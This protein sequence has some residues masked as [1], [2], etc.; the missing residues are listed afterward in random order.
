[1]SP[2]VVS[3]ILLKYA[4]ICNLSVLLFITSF[5]VNVMPVVFCLCR[6]WYDV[7]IFPLMESIRQNK[8][9]PLQGSVLYEWPED[10]LK[11]D[12]VFLLLHTNGTFNGA[13]M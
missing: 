8:Y 4:E 9:C 7:A 12:I 3:M 6:Y 11:P 2:H 5:S 13:R 1:M 10:L